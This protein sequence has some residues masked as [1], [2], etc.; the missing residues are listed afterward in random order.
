[1]GERTF[2]P[3]I[4]ESRWNAEL[5]LKLID[6]WR[7]EGL[8]KFDPNTD[9][10]AIAIDT[11]PPYASARWHVGGAAHYAQID[12]VARYFR[13][14]GYEVL[15]PFGVDRNGLPVEV[16]VERTYGIRYWE[17]GRE[18]FERICRE[19]L[20]EVEKQLIWVVRRLGMSCDLESYYRTDSPEYRSLTQET[21]IELWFRGLI[22]EA[23]Y[24]VNWCPVCR[25]TIA[26][27]EVE[28]SD[29]TDTDL[30]Y[31]K[32]RLEDGG[33]IVVASTRPELLC[34]CAAI[35]FNPGDDRYKGLE[36][37]KAIVPIYGYRVPIIAHPAA[38]TEFGSGLVMVCSYGDQVDV[39]LFRELGLKPR[40]AIDPDGRMNSNAGVYEGFTVEEA[41]M[42]VI[43]DLKAE[44][45]IERIERIKH[46]VPVCW[47]S[48][49]PIEFIHMREF[50]LKQVDFL[51]EVSK[52]V[53][54][55][56]FYPDSA[57]QRLTDW[58]KG[59]KT[60]W[61]ISRR[62]FY[63]T[64]IPIWYCRRCGGANLPRPGK[65]YKPWRDTPPI[66]RCV[67]CGS[68]EF[69]GE[70]RTLDTWMDSSISPLYIAG[71]KRDPKLYERLS[72]S[73]LRPQ[74]YDI[75]R[76]WLYYTIL[77]V[78][79]LTGKP[80]FRYVRI[81]G[82]GLD[83]R[84]EAMHKSKG[85]VV[86]P[87]PFLEK[88]GADAFRF[89]AASEARLG[90]DYRFS[91]SKLESARL[92]LT[93]LWNI[94]RFISQFPVVDKPSKLKPMDEWI[95]AETNRLIEVCV[96][97][98][99]ELD[100][101]DASNSIR[102]FVWSVLADHYIE[103]VKPRAYNS[104]GTFSG[105]EQTSAWY[106]LHKV[107]AIVLKLLAPICPFITD[108]AWRSIYGGTVHR[109]RIPEAIP[110]DD[111]LREYTE[112]ILEFNSG[113]W[114]IKK[115]MGISLNTPLKGVVYASDRIKPFLE[116]LRRMHRIEEVSFD[117]P[118]TEAERISDNLYYLASSR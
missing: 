35:I 3:R 52:M 49:N 5:E 51:D 80:A 6:V 30:V 33:Y 77:R 72:D 44:G 110:V 10:P 48:K 76:T 92:F 40:I 2:K 67:Y 46:R 41:R 25:T 91:E 45:V 88:Y 74:G 93:K 22:Y 78:Y 11:P 83:E 101:F 86:Y 59:V 97:D 57:K 1:M 32:F 82:M 113:L 85:N 84:G 60:D 18:E 99:E 61:P 56:K 34:S 28:Y 38:K 66:D 58:I 96:K 115:K 20:D 42:K 112:Y 65:Y 73:I 64:E 50:Y 90:S 105:E 7:S 62:R 114:K 29:E 102:H 13:M 4:T 118:P 79:E 26:D 116:D 104:D 103:A 37:S 94:A 55:M 111:R 15:F 17:V 75:I 87:E 14:K 71:Y 16:Q 68:T 53:D 63:G 108:A 106:T 107:L 81:S 69:V 117:K 12:M 70:E 98:Y 21:F 109:E 43:E 9:K 27:A 24:P 89:W 23:E 95:L 100:F 31:M 47:R 54:C 8:Y 39:R 36:G 19:Y